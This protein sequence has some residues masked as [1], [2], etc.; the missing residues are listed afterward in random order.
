MNYT[1]FR[2]FAR[3][4]KC[5]QK[6]LN[7]TGTIF[8]LCN[9]KSLVGADDDDPSNP[10]LEM[11]IFEFLTGVLRLARS[12]YV[13]RV[14]TLREQIECDSLSPAGGFYCMMV[15]YDGRL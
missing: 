5:S 9:R 1:Q 6:V 13:Q 10:D 11:L 2:C 14:S 8:K 12:E 4:C 3:D 15:G 7:D